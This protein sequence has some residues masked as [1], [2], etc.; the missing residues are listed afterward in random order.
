MMYNTQHTQ[1]R[2]MPNGSDRFRVRVT[3]PA[4]FGMQQSS[5]RG[6]KSLDAARRYITQIETTLEG[7]YAEA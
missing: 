6:F 4:P 3:Y 2:I 1:L 5:W 7:D